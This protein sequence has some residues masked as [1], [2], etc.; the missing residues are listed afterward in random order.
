MSPKKRNRFFV[1]ITVCVITLAA[2]FL[3]WRNGVVEDKI[4]YTYHISKSCSAEIEAFLNSLED[5][6]DYISFPLGNTTFRD[7]DLKDILRLIV[8][9]D[10]E[11]YG[12]TCAFEPYKYN[13]DSLYYAPYYYKQGDSVYSKNLGNKDYDYFSWNWYLV[14]KRIGK[15]FWTEP[16]FDDGGGNINLI[17]YSVPIY[18]YTDDDKE[19]RGVI[20]VDVSLDWINKIIG[21]IKLKEGDFALLVSKMGTI[22]STD[23]NNKNWRLNET[24]FSIANEQK[25]NGLREMGKDIIKGKTGTGYITKQSGEKYLVNYIPINKGNWSFIVAINMNKN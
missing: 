4:S 1:V 11:I 10:S 3:L 20:T 15:A 8:K 18:N 24:I 17:T 19:F 6:P 21:S 13:K 16:Y 2:F 25:L 23:I 12:S 5:I 7:E 9:N 22:I 14:P